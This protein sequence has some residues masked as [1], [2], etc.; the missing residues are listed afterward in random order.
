LMLPLVAFLVM[1]GTIVGGYAAV[2]SLPGVM[3][4]RRLDRRLRDVSLPMLDDPNAPPVVDDTVVKH[5]REG[6][7]PAMDRRL[8]GS[9]LARLIEQSGTRATPSGIVVVSAALACLGAFL[10][11]L[12]ARQPYAPI[13]AV[14]LGAAAPALW[15]VRR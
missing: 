14:F 4:R 1:A 7:M 15:L 8:A 10:V 3:A 12:A 5:R 13:A 2:A 9:A 6:P 11:T